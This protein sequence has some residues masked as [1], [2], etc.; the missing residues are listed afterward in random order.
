MP[1]K[2]YHHGDLK[3]ALIKAGVEILAKDGVGGLS[4]RK[5]AQQAGVSH[6]AP[7]AHFT[8]K[9]ALIAAIS[10]EGFLILFEQ[11]KA[12]REKYQFDPRRQL[13]EAARAYVRF[14][15]TAPAHFRVTFSSAVER[16]QDYPA[17]VEMIGNSYGQVVK[18]VEGCQAAGILRS[19]PADVMAVSV[20]SVVHGFA[21]LL[22]EGQI[23]HTMF[24]RMTVQELLVVT[25]NQV[26]LVHLD[27]AEFLNLPEMRST[28]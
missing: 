3:N 26:T 14:A 16:E 6:A 18:I 24:E 1:K 15:Q 28:D 22:I 7:Y 9:Q 10:T 21:S 13:V 23:S 8:D 2:K 17:L 19:A 4:L 25:L 12:V 27:P 5:V 11:L 20:W